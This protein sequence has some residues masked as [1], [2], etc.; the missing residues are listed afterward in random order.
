MSQQDGGSLIYSS[1]N[2]NMIHVSEN[3][4]KQQGTQPR[5]ALFSF[6]HQLTDA[7]GTSLV[8]NFDAC[9]NV[10]DINVEVNFVAAD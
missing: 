4:T 1:A 6:N 5:D 2:G 7:T 10:F 8:I 9:L 3:K